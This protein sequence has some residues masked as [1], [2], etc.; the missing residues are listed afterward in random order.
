MKKKKRIIPTYD[1][2]L[3]ILYY[4]IQERTHTHGKIVHLCNKKA[5][6]HK[7]KSHSGLLEIQTLNS[8]VRIHSLGKSLLKVRTY[9]HCE[10]EGRTTF[11][12]CWC[13]LPLAYHP[14]LKD[15]LEYPAPTCPWSLLGVVCLYQCWHMEE[16]WDSFYWRIWNGSKGG[17]VPIRPQGGP[18]M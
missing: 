2:M 3:F 11:L 6:T 8:E 9:I 13:W 15:P 14:N 12:T 17:H 18:C 10:N 4:F 16:R 7:I 5:G 1:R